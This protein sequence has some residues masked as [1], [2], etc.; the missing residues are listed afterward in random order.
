MMMVVMT[1]MMG[2]G[3]ISWYYG[4]GKNDKSNDSKK[5]RTQLHG[6]TPSR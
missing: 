3:R 6:R 1:M 2:G 4:P 5:Q